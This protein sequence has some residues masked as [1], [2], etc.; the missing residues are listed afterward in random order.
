MIWVSNLYFI[1]A[2]SSM[3]SNKKDLVILSIA[4][5]IVWVTAP[6]TPQFLT[7]YVNYK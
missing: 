6:F 3:L 4:V 7:S 2:F 1:S 5:K